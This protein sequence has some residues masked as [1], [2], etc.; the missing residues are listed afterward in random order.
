MKNLKVLIFILAFAIVLLCTA[1]CIAEEKIVGNC[2]NGVTW[3]YDRGILT[4]SGSGAMFDYPNEDMPW[5]YRHALSQYITYIVIEDGV[6]SIGENAFSGCLDLKSVTIPKSVTAIGDKAFYTCQRLT[7]VYYGGSYDNR[8]SIQ[9]GS[10]NSFFTDA[11]WAYDGSELSTSGSCGEELNWTYADYT[12]RINGR[13]AMDDFELGMAP[14]RAFR[15]DITSV[16]LDEEL[17]EIGNS[18]FNDF[19]GIS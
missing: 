8:T 15:Y 14:W 11:S 12:L 5:F 9:I 16:I 13:G 19:R 2:G 7:A 6:T 17:T 4:I 3:A 10:D 18:A 1:M